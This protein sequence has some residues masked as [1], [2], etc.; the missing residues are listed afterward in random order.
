M[1]S[2]YINCLSTSYFQV[3]VRSCKSGDK[4]IDRIL[5]FCYSSD[6]R[7]RF[8]VISRDELGGLSV[9]FVKVYVKVWIRA[10]LAAK[11]PQN[12]LYFLKSLAFHLEIAAFTSKR[13]AQFKPW[14]KL[15]SVHRFLSKLLKRKL[16]PI[17]ILNLNKWLQRMSFTVI[18]YI[19]WECSY[20]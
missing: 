9:F 15:K 8:R 11:A 4:E 17:W 7:S 20:I 5:K 6:S 3:I 19:M 16:L 14:V 1:W 10:R 13:L 18:R 2:F 12:D